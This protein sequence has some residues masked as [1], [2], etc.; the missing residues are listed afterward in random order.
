VGGE[1]EDRNLTV[2]SA[3]PRCGQR[4]LHRTIHAE[5]VGIAGHQPCGKRLLE[6]VPAGSG[7]NLSDHCLPGVTQQD[8]GD[9]AHRNHLVVPIRPSKLDWFQEG[10][11]ES[12]PSSRAI[13]SEYMIVT[14]NEAGKNVLHE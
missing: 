10:T 8:F 5:S 1:A 9:G 2:R 7:G 4:S 6:V 3:R 14:G 12:L 13:N 11:V